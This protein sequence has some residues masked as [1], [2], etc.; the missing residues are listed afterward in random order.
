M[1]YAF[2]DANAAERRE[3]TVLRNVLQ[4]HS[5]GL[6]RCDASRA[7]VGGA[8]KRAFDDDIWELSIPTP[9]STQSENLAAE[10]PARLP[11]A[12]SGCF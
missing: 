2:N 7:S 11:R 9:N 3:N 6:D 5:Q 10:Q 8:Y 12:A 4:P 1:L